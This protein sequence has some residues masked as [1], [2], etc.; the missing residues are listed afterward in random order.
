MLV[1]TLRNLKALLQN[2]LPAKL[3]QI[4]LERADGV[5]LEDIQSFFIE[6]GSGSHTSCQGGGAPPGIWMPAW[7][8]QTSPSWGRPQVPTMRFLAGGS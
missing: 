2:Q 3:D 5:T 4:E 7:D 1:D 6:L 8:T